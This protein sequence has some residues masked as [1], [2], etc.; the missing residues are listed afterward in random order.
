MEVV[1]RMPERR[2]DDVMDE[3]NCSMHQAEWMVHEKLP[4]GMPM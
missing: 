4:I 1:G 3:L 2:S